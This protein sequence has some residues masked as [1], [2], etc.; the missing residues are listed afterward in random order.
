MLSLA[1][2]KDLE[3]IGEAA[4][5]ISQDCQ[6]RHPEL[7]W[8]NMIGMKNRLVHAYYGINLDIV[9]QTVSQDLLPLLQVIDK[10]IIEES[11]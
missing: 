9:W 1:V 10:I 4:S 2:I 7:S 8:S 3:I 6:N 11:D 5:R